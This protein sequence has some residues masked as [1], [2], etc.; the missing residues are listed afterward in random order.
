MVDI[1]NQADSRGI[2]IQRTG[3]SKVH[4]PLLI[5]DGGKVQQVTAQIK[6]TASLSSDIRGTHMSRL[7]EILTDW[8]ATPIKLLDVEKI[9]LDAQEKLDADFS[10][11]QIAFKYFIEKVAPITEKKSLI[12]VDCILEGELKKFSRMKFNLGLTVPFTSLCPCS[13]EIS[14]FGAHNQ[15]SVCKV[16][17]EIAD[18]DAAKNFDIEKIFHLIESQGSSK[19]FP[20]LKREDEKFVTEYAYQNPKFVEDILRDVVISLRGVENIS[21]F[22]VECENFESIHNHNAYAYF[23]S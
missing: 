13:R 23:K 2:K 11:I 20:I 18:I 3:V 1:Q 21:S 9:L 22:E 17:L 12:D 7:M 10:A 5:S 8:T 4:L 14:N 6:F 16:K 15:R 19:I